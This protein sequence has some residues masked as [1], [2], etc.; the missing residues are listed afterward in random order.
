MITN[1]I[2]FKASAGDIL[3]RIGL[4]SF[5]L[6]GSLT[7]FFYPSEFLELLGANTLASSIATP[8]F[9]VY[10]IGI[11]DGLL[12]LFILLGRWRKE[13]AV[14]AGLWIVA[15]MYVTTSE[16]LFEVIEHIGVLSFISYYYSTYKKTTLE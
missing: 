12:F 11:N 8:Q 5:F 4:S 6:I 9:W 16:G 13:V 1:N 15:V 7:A 14:W 10:L 2:H 3:F